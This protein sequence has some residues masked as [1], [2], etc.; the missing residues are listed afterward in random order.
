MAIPTGIRTFAKMWGGSLKTGQFMCTLQGYLMV[1]CGLSS[2]YWMF[3]I[4]FVMYLI[5]YHPFIWKNKFKNPTK[6]LLI[7]NYITPMIIAL[8]P[9]FSGEYGN[10]GKYSIYYI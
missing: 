4:S 10:V 7:V 1:G 8:I 9:I 2:F 6:T 3:S 5:I